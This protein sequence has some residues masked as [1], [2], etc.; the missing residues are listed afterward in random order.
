V[1]VMPGFSLSRPS[2]P[3]RVSNYSSLISAILAAWVYF[4]FRLLLQ[5]CTHI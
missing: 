4:R 5:C 1:D 2:H 3:M